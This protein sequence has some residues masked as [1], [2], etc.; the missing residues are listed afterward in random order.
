MTIAIDADDVAAIRK[1]LRTASEDVGD[2]VP[3][4]PGAAAFG[5][6]VLGSAVASF[7]AAMRREAERLAQRW[8]ALEAG[9]RE[10]FDDMSAVED[11]L[12]AGI[13]RFGGAFGARVGGAVGVNIGGVTEPPRSPGLLL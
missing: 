5:P 9:V 11:E 3:Q 2:A 7:E 13:G 6:Q 1:H 10:T 8:T 12:V 4:L